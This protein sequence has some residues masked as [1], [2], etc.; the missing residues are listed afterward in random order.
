MKNT[1]FQSITAVF[2]IA[3]MVTACVDPQWILARSL[4][5]ILAHLGEPKHLST[6]KTPLSSRQ[7]LTHSQILVA[8]CSQPQ[9][10][11]TAENIRES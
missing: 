9:L 4:K 8:P 11:I 2:V 10:P 3:M 6:H 7:F 1:K 5:G